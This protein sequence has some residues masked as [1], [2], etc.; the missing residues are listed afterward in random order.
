MP[1]RRP[2]KPCGNCPRLIARMTSTLIG[3]LGSQGFSHDD[4]FV[5]VIANHEIVAADG[6]ESIAFVEAAGA[7]VVDEDAE[8]KLSSA[9]PQCLIQRPV[10]ER[11]RDTDAVMLFE[12]V[13]LIQLQ[14]GA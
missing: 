6:F 9:A 10:H 7:V 14:S 1:P 5:R 2:R 11:A 13:E 4:V 3:T 12:D 8:E